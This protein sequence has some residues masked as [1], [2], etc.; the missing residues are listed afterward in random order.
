MSDIVEQ[1]I[2]V[3][4]DE[5]SSHLLKSFKWKDKYLN[6][7]EINAELEDANKYI[8]YNLGDKYRAFFRNRYELMYLIIKK[9]FLWFYINFNQDL[10]KFLPFIGESHTP[11]CESQRDFENFINSL[12]REKYS[13][14]N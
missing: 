8:K 14:Q 7:D 12:A 1:A 6:I 2:E 13:G 5:R 4:S 9:K 10:E 3:L 11:H